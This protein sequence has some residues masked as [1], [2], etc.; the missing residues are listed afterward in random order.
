MAF[1]T[2][3]CLKIAFRQMCVT[4]CGRFGP[5]ER[6]VVGCGKR[7]WPKYTAKWGML[8]AGM[9]FQTHSGQIRLKTRPVQNTQAKRTDALDKRTQLLPASTP[10]PPERFLPWQR[11]PLLGIRPKV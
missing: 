1:S 3:A 6:G 4:L 8:M 2:R 7:I 9:N 10:L 5:D 11:S